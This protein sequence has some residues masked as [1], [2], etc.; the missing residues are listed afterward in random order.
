MQLLLMRHAMSEQFS[1]TALQDIWQMM[2][3]MA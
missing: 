2:K 1:T 3:V